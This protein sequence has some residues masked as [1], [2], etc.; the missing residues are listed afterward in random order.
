MQA[1]LGQMQARLGHKPGGLGK[2]QAC[3]LQFDAFN[4]NLPPLCASHDW[5]SKAA[6]TTSLPAEIIVT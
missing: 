1:R 6:Y 4:D 2:G 3:N 5:K